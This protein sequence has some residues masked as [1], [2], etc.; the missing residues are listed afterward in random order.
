MST[1]IKLKHIHDNSLKKKKEEKKIECKSE[2]LEGV[3]TQRK[4]IQMILILL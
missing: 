1:Q 3:K 4:K 2:V